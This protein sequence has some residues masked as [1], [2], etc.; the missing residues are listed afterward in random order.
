MQ[1]IFSEKTRR[2]LRSARQEA[3]MTLEELADGTGFALTTFS[4][5]ENGHDTPSPRLLE[6]WIRRLRL[7]EEWLAEGTGRKFQPA[8]ALFIIPP[9]ELKS[10]RARARSLRDQAAFLIEQAEQLEFEV[11][12]SEAYHRDKARAQDDGKSDPR[13]AGKRK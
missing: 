10:S 3:G 11:R 9:N 13:G 6:A 7:N 1:D 8:R 5:V 4:S 2:R 12:E